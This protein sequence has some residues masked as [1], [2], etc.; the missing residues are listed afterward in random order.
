MNTVQLDA[1]AR[2]TITFRRIP[3]GSTDITRGARLMGIHGPKVSIQSEVLEN[4]C[5]LDGA[6]GQ[7]LAG[8]ILSVLACHL[9]QN[10]GGTFDDRVLVCAIRRDDG[11]PVEIGLEIQRFRDCGVEHIVL[12]RIGEQSLCN[13]PLEE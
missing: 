2:S 6:L 1:I 3:A 8:V 10:P 11:T 5:E 7:N 12:V 4:Y 9:D 13:N